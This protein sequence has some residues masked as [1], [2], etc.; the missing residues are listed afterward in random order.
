MTKLKLIKKLHSVSSRPYCA[1]SHCSSLDRL[2]RAYNGHSILVFPDLI[3]TEFSPPLDD[4]ER[5]T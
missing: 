1:L 3:Q 4:K 2:W 5:A